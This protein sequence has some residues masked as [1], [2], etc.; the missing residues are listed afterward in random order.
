MGR[1][2]EIHAFA[3]SGGNLK[4]IYIEVGGRSFAKSYRR[5]C[6]IFGIFSSFIFDGGTENVVGEAMAAAIRPGLVRSREE[7]FVTSKLWSS[8]ASW[9]YCPSCSKEQTSWVI[10]SSLA[11]CWIPSV[12]IFDGRIL[13]KY[14]GRRKTIKLIVYIILLL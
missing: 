7:L 8:D 14:M 4:L 13:L 10:S 3:W 9:S 12:K 2:G 11:C 6:K 1:G 5:L